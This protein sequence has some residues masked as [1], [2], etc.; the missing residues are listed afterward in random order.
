MKHEPNTTVSHYRILSEI[1]KGGMGE[2]YLAED[3]KLDRQV[4][5]KILPAEFAEDKD[6]MSRFVREAK[7]ASALNHPN[8]IT[9]Y[10]INK[11]DG[12]HFISTEYIKGQTLD[13]YAKAKS[14][15]L[16][17]VLDIAIQV[18]SALDEAHNAGIVHRDI[19]PDNIMVRKD[20]LVKI[21]DF[22]IAKL[23]TT[24]ARDG[25][26][27]TA[28]QSQTQAGMII[29]TP[30]YMSPE[31]ARGKTVDHQTDI[32]SFGVVFYEMLSGS[33]PFA[34]DTVSDVIAAVLTKE[35]RALINIPAE[36]TEI[37]NKALKKDK[38]NRYQTAKDL[39]HD[40]KEVKQEL[41]FREKLKRTSGT[42]DIEPKTQLSR[43]GATAGSDTI[44]QIQN[45][46]SVVV[47]PFS[48][49][50]ADAE[51]EYFSDGLTDEVIS[52][53]SKI[54]S[55]RVISRNSA[56]KLKGTEKDL[57]TIAEEL[58]VQYVLDGSCRKAG[59]D[60]R[61]S[62][63]LIE[64]AT[65]ANLWAEKYSGSLDDIFEIQESVS[66]SIAEAL[67][68]TLTTV[69]VEQIEERPI[70]DARAYD[71]YLR[72]RTHFQK[73]SPEALDRTIEL[74]KQGLEI[75]GENELLYAA[76]GYAYYFYF[77]WISKLDEN[78]LRL[79]KECRQKL[80]AINP[81][82]SHGYSLQGFLSYSEGD[83][84][85]AI[86]SLEESIE[87]E[88][89]NTEA[90]HALATHYTFIDDFEG[91][92]KSIEKACLL[93]PL[94]PLNTMVKGF[95]YIYNGDFEQAMP[96]V[97][98]GLAMDPTAPLP[99]W[100]TAAAYAWCGN[101]EQ[102]IAYAD[103]LADTAPGWIYTEHVLF[104]KHALLG[105]KE[106]ALQH[107]TPD[108]DKE[109]KFDS[110]FAL[111]IAH[112]F[113]LIDETE[114]ALD[115]L[116]ISVRA[117]MVNHRFLSELDPL[118]EN[119]RSEPRFQ[120]L[121]TEAKQL[122][123]AINSS[124][125]GS[126]PRDEPESLEEAGTQMLPTPTT[127]EKR[128][129]STTRSEGGFRVAVLPFKYR[130]E[131]ADLENLAEGMP[132]EIVTGLSRFPYLRVISRSAVLGDE[133]TGGEGRKTG[134]EFGIRYVLEGSLRQV[135]TTV[136]IAVQLVDTATGEH[137][138]AETYDRKFEA[139]RIFEIQD[140]LVARV[141][142][143]IAD[144]HGVL[145][146]SMAGSLRNKDKQQ[147][148]PE[149]SILYVFGY[150]ERLSPEEHLVA[151]DLLERITEEFPDRG[152]C[153]AMLAILYC[154][155]Y[156][157][158]FNLRPDPLGRALGAA[159]KAVELEPASYLASQ[160]L[161]FAFFF[162]R[163]FAAFERLAKRTITL[164][165]M[166]GGTIAVLGLFFACSGQW[167]RGCELSREAMELN[168]HFPGWYRL[169]FVFNAY[170]QKDYQ[171]VLSEA[172][173]INIPNYFWTLVMRTAALGHLGESEKAKEAL[174]DLLV[175]RPD[176]AGK[177][178]EE[179]GHWLDAEFVEVLIE[180]LRKAGFETTK[181]SNQEE[182]KTQITKNQAAAEEV[183]QSIAVL[184]F[185]NMSA[186]EENEYF[187]DG[188]A[189][190]LLNA[191]SKIEDLKVAARTSAFSF[192]DRN[193]NVSEIGEKLSVENVLEGSVR[194]SGD[195][196]RITV[197][198]INASDGYQI[199][200]ERYDREMK[201]IFDVQDEIALAVVDALK[202]QLFGDE[203]TAVLKHGTRNKE[204]YD[205]Y[206]K[207]R[208]F[209]NKFTE[210]SFEQALELYKQAIAIDGSYAK[211][212]V[213]IGE[214]YFYQSLPDV[215]MAKF[216][217]EEAITKIT[218]AAE[219]AIQID[220][221][222]AEAWAL[223]AHIKEKTWDFQGAKEAYRHSFALDVNY[224]T[225]HSSYGIFLSA[226]G[227]D[228]EAVKETLLAQKLDPFSAM[229]NTTPL[230]CLYY[231]R[232]YEEAIYHWERITELELTF[233][234]A[235]SFG[236]L[237]Y[238]ETKRYAEAI[239]IFREAIRNSN[240]SNTALA[241]LGHALAVSGEKIE[242]NE[243]LNE[244][245]KK[246]KTSYVSS[247]GIALVYTG[248]GEKDK[249][250]ESLITACGE[251]NLEIVFL[252][253]EPRFDP[254][255]DD[256]RFQ[257][258]ISHLGF[259]NN[260]AN[261]TK[262]ILE[263]K[264]VMLQPDST[265]E[266]TKAEISPESTTNPKS[267]TQKPKSKW[268]L[269]GLLG[270]IFLTVGFLSYN[271]F[272]S[273][274]NQIDSIAVMPFVNESGNEDVEYL[275]DG[276]TETLIS[277]LSNLPNLN[278][279]ARSSVF[280]Y[281]GKNTD[282]K[283]IGTELNVQ[284][285]LNG[286]IVQRG[287]Q[288]T[289]NLELVDAKTENVIWSDK[290]D[291][292]TSDLVTLQ[293]EIA[294][295]VSTKLKT[296][297]SGAEVD[298]VSNVYTTNS[299]AYQLYLKGNYYTT[300]LTKEGFRKGNEFFEQAIL[301]DP[302]Y[303]L[304]YNGIAFNQLAAM[305]WFSEPKIAGPKAK[306]AVKKAVALDDRLAETQLLRGMVAHWVE[307]DWETAEIAF[308]RAIELDPSNSRP[309]GYYAWLLAN[310][311]RNDEAV[312]AAGKGQKLDPISA[313]ANWFLGMA[314]IA[315]G[316][317]DEAVAKLQTAIDLEPTYFYAYSFLGRAYLQAGKKQEALRAFERAHQ[318]ENE[319][320]ENLANLAYAQ[321]VAGNKVEAQKMIDQLQEK[322]K[323]TYVAPYYLAIAYA[324]L[325][326]NEQVFKHL[327]RAYADK[328]DSL[329]LY[330]TAD[331]QMKDIRSNRRYMDLLKLMGLPES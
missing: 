160:S 307:W 15:G 57:K 102:A 190:E 166:C 269:F 279:K 7:S 68:I 73:G 213:G 120:S 48:N 254:L 324:G 24:P 188:L 262:E 265:N 295:D 280:R 47:L 20:G 29:G 104:L 113:A 226:L 300:K 74:L 276:M 241:C 198:L 206:L 103:K 197:Q 294:K 90:L 116:E 154:N 220:K 16:S 97:E 219:K 238:V 85:K 21:L 147:F 175:S 45:L 23:T 247:Y 288:L 256:P 176:I 79:A 291:R 173:K 150:I 329:V 325:G 222:L 30:N 151:R 64:C 271:Y 72:A 131:N 66:R 167:E 305:D 223:L 286:R 185:T 326:D 320:S 317:T 263:A 287:D 164:N 145:V 233:P 58:N 229:I 61:I 63:Q 36:L 159:Q 318:L 186:D 158:G 35:P 86:L 293:S 181:P 179:F 143:T 278:V 314:L 261:R 3:T 88:P 242:A 161:A 87:L 258:I 123:V 59:D 281:K 127:A 207:A 95:V 270:L 96:W 239:K 52:D 105:E 56:M 284:A 178:P 31:Q 187:C 155:E 311:G 310:I 135:G 78:Y 117:G 142:S 327:E 212:Y 109:A 297:L 83:I 39:L 273:G 268:W 6:R 252:N 121:M 230:I 210:A 218:A 202:L 216:S 208:F 199:W 168:P 38:T 119:I 177:T 182:Q 275:S 201:D 125:A 138:W 84:E 203:K 26:A 184:P 282:A 8:I 128:T 285:I 152:N 309:Y 139:E 34:G 315:S 221:N 27:A 106:Q 189:E 100:A 137:L 196:L 122:S 43:A 98:R 266:N 251:R 250:I 312:A 133:S 211:A 169:P 248:L 53:L 264:T 12:L 89:A 94:L 60:L 321:G 115:F 235:G 17:S 136:R 62:V 191:L 1:G 237:A 243:I 107:Y 245:L 215:P 157:Y 46:K 214:I 253:V 313:E 209:F 132:E 18:A 75:I 148:T 194:K 81:N 28:I 272:I 33:S 195:N 22:G 82:S 54:R 308:K 146:H 234:A 236:G 65:D 55:L 232:R 42:G 124:T 204:A 260:E 200:S 319:N 244:L 99:L 217:P 298:K 193:A 44:S 50:G 296:K 126:D 67:Q 5:L 255:R 114:K 141:V 91:A 70:A 162:R 304:A 290:Y 172:Q 323:D 41:Q 101:Q 19:K 140:E 277:S 303:A 14:L 227:K 9:I 331:P 49:I 156:M 259:T 330:L 180:G 25:E 174:H 231:A 11:I 92:M 40:L 299:E 129:D 153:W 171:E 144:W 163:E 274:S 130:G 240:R 224:P 10:E 51:D 192:K 228:D 328:S 292:K 267:K 170:R 301:L 306:R 316:R 76:L 134:E 110:H 80:L 165:S 183:S 32:F 225:T 249:A 111:H 246:S 289:L 118:L 37:L 93:D 2:V 322:S 69:E 205:L 77:R 13:G 302:N 283:T 71:L 257:E 149:E 112:C 4:A 108:F